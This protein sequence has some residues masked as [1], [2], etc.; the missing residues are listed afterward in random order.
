MSVL[1]TGTLR[2]SLPLSRRSSSDSQPGRSQSPAL[3]G[4]PTPMP[5]SQSELRLPLSPSGRSTAVEILKPQNILM[6]LPDFRTMVEMFRLF[7]NKDS[8]IV[9]LSE[10]RKYNKIHIF[11][12]ILFHCPVS[13]FMRQKIGCMSMRRRSKKNNFPPHTSRWRHSAVH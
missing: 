12:N 11:M 8:C 3:S 9:S 5:V 4:G 13:I 7:M 2:A 1:Q 10:C 6:H